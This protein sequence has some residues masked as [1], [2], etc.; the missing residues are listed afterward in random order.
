MPRVV[1]MAEESV[2]VLRRPYTRIVR[3]HEWHIARGGLTVEKK[4]RN[5]NQICRENTVVLRTVIVIKSTEN[6]F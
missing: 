4:I 2:I 5:C 6:I 3:P 1:F